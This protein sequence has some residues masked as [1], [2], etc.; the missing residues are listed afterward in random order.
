MNDVARTIVANNEAKKFHFKPFFALIHVLLLGGSQCCWRC[1]RGA[2]A[3]LMINRGSE[4]SFTN[5]TPSC[6]RQ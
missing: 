6:S 5:V 2:A 4:V 1:Q 3:A